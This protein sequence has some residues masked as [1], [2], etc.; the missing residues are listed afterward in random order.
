MEGSDHVD[1]TVFEIGGTQGQDG[2]KK[3]RYGRNIDGRILTGFDVQMHH[4][5]VVD[6]LKSQGNLQ[7]DVFEFG[8]LE[9]II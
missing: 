9:V 7:K 1:S 5:R 2:L 4:A 6:V 8:L 3:T